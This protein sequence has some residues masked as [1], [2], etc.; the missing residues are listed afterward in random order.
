VFEQTIDAQ[1]NATDTADSNPDTI[2]I[3]S[4]P[5]ACVLDARFRALLRSGRHAIPFDGSAFSFNGMRGC[6]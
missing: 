3:L 5:M 4:Q 6:S 2:T 1:G